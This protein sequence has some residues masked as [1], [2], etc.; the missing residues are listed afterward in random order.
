MTLI[1]TN[2]KLFSIECSE[3]KLVSG[4]VLRDSLPA[5]QVPPIYR[6]AEQLWHG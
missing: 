2:A 5:N 4:L 3:I 1:S 6:G